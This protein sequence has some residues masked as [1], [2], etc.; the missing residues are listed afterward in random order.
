VPTASASDVGDLDVLKIGTLM[1]D[2]VVD[3]SRHIFD[4]DPIFTRRFHL[5]RETHDDKN[6][7]NHE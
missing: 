4:Y 3:I 5:I 1:K 2:F 6:H 7:S